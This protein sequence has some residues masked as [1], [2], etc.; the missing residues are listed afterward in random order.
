MP[1]ILESKRGLIFGV[2]DKRSI[3]WAIAQAAAREGAELA[4][5]YQ[6]ER[7]E[8][9]ARQL[10]DPAGIEHLVV[11]DVTDDGQISAAMDA[12]GEALG[13]LDF[14]VHAI[15][16]ALPEDLAGAY[17]DTSRGGF[18]LA[19][20]I[21]AFSLTALARAARPLLAESG[22]SIVALTYLGSERVVPRYN[23][24][25]TCK[26]ALES[27]IRYLAADLGLD[28]I[29]VNGISAGPIRTLAARGIAGFS[30]MLAHHREKAPLGRNTDPAEVA[31]AAV[32]L[33]S[34]L[35]RGITGEVIYVDGGY[36]IMGV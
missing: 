26:A 30:G 9:N 16:H 23:V 15:A 7:L 3:A 19:Q 28:D 31:D 24:M 18:L 34:D 21:S 33:T 17:V 5:A 14:L 22:G 1:R 36:H 4:L 32:F 6:N 12:A 27:G 8:R 29:R 20:E 11:C 13:G 25:G 35:A 10:A 2:R